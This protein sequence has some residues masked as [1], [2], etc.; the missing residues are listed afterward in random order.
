MSEIF[1]PSLEPQGDLPAPTETLKSPDDLR[2]EAQQLL[3]K[4]DSQAM[5]ILAEP[6]EQE[7]L[8]QLEQNGANTQ[9]A[10]DEFK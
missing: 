4:L 7:F 1:T 10:F 9:E 5:K 2:S 8:A 3:T 6:Q